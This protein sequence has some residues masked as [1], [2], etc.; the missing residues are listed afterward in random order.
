[1]CT[2]D[3]HDGSCPACETD[4]WIVPRDTQDRRAGPT[5]APGT[6]CP[7]CGVS[8]VTGKPAPNCA[9]HGP[10]AH[11]VWCADENYADD[12]CATCN[13]QEDDPMTDRDRRA[14]AELYFDE[15]ESVESHKESAALSSAG[16]LSA[17]LAIKRL[18]AE[19]RDR[20]PEPEGVRDEPV[21]VTEEPPVGS[22][23]TDREGDV[24][25]RREDGWALWWHERPGWLADLYGS[26]LDP[27]PTV[28][29]Q[30]PLR[31]TTDEDRE[32]VGLPVEEAPADDGLA[33]WER[34]LF[35]PATC[36]GK[37]P[38]IA[39]GG[40]DCTC[41]GNPRCEKADTP[42]EWHGNP[43][44]A[45]VDPDEALAKVVWD[46]FWIGT[47]IDAKWELNDERPDWL[48]VARTAREHIEA[49][50]DKCYAKEDATAHDRAEKADDS[51]RHWRSLALNMEAK[52]LRA[53]DERDE[54]RRERDM[55][56]SEGSAETRA[57][58][59]ASQHVLALAGERDEWKARHAA[60]RDDVERE[61][62]EAPDYPM[63]R[64]LDRDD[65]RGQ[66]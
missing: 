37:C 44:P 18:L 10:E 32:R 23:V 59:N 6:I 65:E 42:E 34:E 54:A 3:R 13:P 30:A 61:Y 39:G 7:R 35:R 60:L 28:R 58:G 51:T 33:E 9:T 52:R 49:E 8:L 19:I 1:M 29:A 20:L 24:W 15:A 5:P 40:Y 46:A 47:D 63:A 4:E 66:A 12:P 16:A 31:L 38:P 11:D 50:M 17:L 36:C 56:E 53:E 45:D 57:L 41:E 48:R 22:Q 2:T 25:E 21:D 64:I 26:G 14:E 62:E 27:W 55:A 43:A